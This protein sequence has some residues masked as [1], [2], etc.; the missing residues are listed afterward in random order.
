MPAALLVRIGVPAGSGWSVL[1]PIDMMRFE[2][3]APV[4]HRGIVAGTEQVSTFQCTPAKTISVKPMITWLVHPCTSF[5]HRHS[6]SPFF[7]LP[8]ELHIGSTNPVQSWFARMSG[9]VKD[10]HISTDCLGRDQIGILRHIAGT[11]DLVQVID[12]LDDSHACRR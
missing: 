7:L 10:I 1:M 9:P 8:L 11:I 6:H 5:A 4:A 3:H 12:A 2:W